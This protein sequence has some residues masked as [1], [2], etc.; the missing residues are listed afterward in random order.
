MNAPSMP[1]ARSQTPL[2]REAHALTSHLT[3]G[4]MP[5]AL[6]RLS[7]T[8]EY[9][10]ILKLASR[11][12]QLNAQGRSICDLTIG[13]FDT[14]LFPLPDHL[15]TGIQRAYEERQNNYSPVD[16]EQCLREAVSALIEQAFK[17]RYAADGEVMIAGGARPLL[18]AAF[19]ALVDPGESIVYPAPSWNTMCYATLCGGRGVAVPTS[20]DH[21]FLPTAADL[22]PHLDRA[23]VLSLCSPHNPTGAMFSRQD[24]EEICDL[25]LAENQ[26]RGTAR[27][28]LY[29]LFD[30]VYWMLTHGDHNPH[31]PVQLRPELKE[32]TIIVDGGSKAF[33]ATGVRVGWS[34]APQAVTDKMKLMIE[35]IGAVAP[36]AE[37]L[38]TAALLQHRELR[39]AYLH[40]FSGKIHDSLSLLH[41]GIQAMRAEGLPVDSLEPMGGIYLSLR[42]E[43]IGM[44]TQEGEPLRSANDLSLYLIEHADLA[45]VPFS[46]FGM[47]DDC[48]W[49]RAAVCTVSADTIASALPRLRTALLRLHR[50]DAYS[51]GPAPTEK[52]WPK[53]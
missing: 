11:V 36:K 2:E 38:A 52:H 33:A 40:H 5:A 46:A 9:S 18:Y 34:T 45:L 37:Q 27:K 50:D 21:R 39:E 31:H 43:V 26:H 7:L 3:H 14:N 42:L 4:G 30:Q 49:F 12:E 6:S 29:L 1:A 24:L 10:Q 47:Q 23:T 28:P 20:A 15:R 25:V 35:H 53:Q 16:G 41:A 17:V 51:H 22:A 8:L 19:L 44:R 13:D 48:D 32:Y